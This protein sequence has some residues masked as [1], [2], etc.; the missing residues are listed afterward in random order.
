MFLSNWGLTLNVEI[1]YPT[2]VFIYVSAFFRIYV[3]SF[4]GSFQQQTV[5]AMAAH[6]ESQPNSLVAVRGSRFTVHGY[7]SS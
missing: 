2:A 7:V 4:W 1:Q 6:V 5:W 3:L